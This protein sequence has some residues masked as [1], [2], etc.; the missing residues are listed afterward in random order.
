MKKYN[1]VKRILTLGMVMTMGVSLLTGC[2]AKKEVKDFASYAKNIE[3]IKLSDEVRIVAL[4]EATH[5]NKEFQELKLSVFAHLVETTP[6]RA[7]AIEG[8]FGSCLIAND[9]IVHDIG[10]AENAVK[11]LGFEIY[12]TDEML[13][14]VQWMHDYNATAKEDDKVRFYGF[15][16]QRNEVA[17]ER[18]R[19]FY[20]VV[21]KD[22]GSEYMAQWDDYYGESN[23]SLSPENLTALKELVNEMIA[24]MEAQKDSYTKMTDEETYAYALQSATCLLQN[25][26]LYDVSNEYMGYADLRDQYM[27]ENVKWILDREENVHGTKLMIAGHNGHVAKV[28]N[29]AYTNMG[30]YLSEEF[31]DAYYVI[32][33]DFYKTNCSIAT[34]EAREDYKFCSDD[35]LAKAVGKMENNQYYLDFDEAQASEELSTLLDSNMPTGS[36]GESYSFLMKFVKTSYQLRIP[37][38]KLYDGMIFVY[39]ATPI[40]VWDYQEK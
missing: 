18:I 30:S 28:V 34:K 31:G 25:L 38:N 24:D 35:P 9:Y 21:S 16:M 40:E 15:D 22:K 26:D 36:L 1:F 23:G 29:S 11:N 20:N 19:A 8:D 13:E 37:P 4:G 3:E 32:G 33:T 39:E 14:L 2:S 17:R 12:R 10:S 27:K 5:G 7:F 6:V